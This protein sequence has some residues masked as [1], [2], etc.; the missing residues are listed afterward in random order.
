MADLSPASTTVAFDPVL[1]LVRV[2][3]P[4]GT[5]DEPEKGQF[6]LAFQDDDSWRAA[7]ARGENQ[8]EAQCEMGARMGCS[9]QASRN[10]QPVWW[11]RLMPGGSTAALDSSREACEERQMMGCLAKA[12]DS[13]SR[14]ARN[15]CQA[16]Y[17][18]L[19]I[20]NKIELINL[21]FLDKKTQRIIAR[22][23]RQIAEK[24]HEPEKSPSALRALQAQKG[25]LLLIGNTD[26]T[27][28][29]F[30]SAP[31]SNVRSSRDVSRGPLPVESVQKL[32]SKG[33]NGGRDLRGGKGSDALDGYEGGLI[34]PKK[35][36]IGKQYL[37]QLMSLST[38]EGEGEGEGDVGVWK[39]VFGFL[40]RS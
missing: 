18:D 12:K 26:N 39:K 11:R 40:R 24:P 16:V 8:M 17:R 4:A 20:A 5:D 3:V 15:S 30:F 1:P 31:A 23:A 6:L 25:N 9:L 37:P 21:R 29:G 34:H 33:K 22:K 28:N 32:G 19:R 38:R 7:W 10:C 36:S 13:C 27:E 14:M 2:P 35:N